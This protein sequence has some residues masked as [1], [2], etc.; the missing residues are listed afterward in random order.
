MRIYI[1]NSS[2][3]PRLWTGAAVTGFALFFGM[4]SQFAHAA[5]VAKLVNEPPL[6]L[7]KAG[8]DKPW[9]VAKEKGA[10]FPAGETLLGG[11]GTALDSANGAVQ[12]RLMGDPNGE[13]PFPIVESAITLEEPKDVDM[14]FVMDRGQVDLINKK[15]EGAAKVKISLLD[16]SAIVTLAKPGDRIAI[17]IYG[18]WP[19]G[20]RFVKKPKGPHAPALAVVALAIKGEIE[21]K[22]QTRT[23]TLEAPPGPALVRLEDLHDH[24]FHVQTLREIP[25]W[26]DAIE[27][28]RYKNVKAAAAK[29]RETALKSSLSEAFDKFVV[30][31]NPI[32]RR[33]AVFLMA[34][35]DDLTRLTLALAAT[36]HLDVWE[37][38]VIAFRNWIG[39]GPGQDEKLYAI[40]MHHC[41]FPPGEA[42]TVMQLLH[43]YGPD[44][45]SKPETFEALIDY[46]ESDRLAL[47]GLAYWHLSRLVPEGKKIGYNP[48]ASKEERAKK[49]KEWQALIPAGTLPGQPKVTPKGKE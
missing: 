38:A 6:L 22:G 35:T 40:L 47:R 3:R 39:R 37:A 34:G 29:L 8:P 4:A 20:V 13:S 30:S 44:Q 9:E 21:I 49:I 17:E 2:S 14:A 33:L 31:E 42:E 19:S 11:F 36:K 15:Q 12:L 23:V 45:L 41:K 32:E 10:E 27:S 16:R 43:S 24:E 46:L 18:R 48:L 28:D 26:I 1:L 7:Q 25:K 5:A